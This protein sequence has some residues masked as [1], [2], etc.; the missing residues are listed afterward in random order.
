M[1]L[2]HGVLTK[3]A[4]SKWEPSW[5]TWNHRRSRSQVKERWRPGRCVWGHDGRQLHSCFINFPASSLIE[6]LIVHT[7]DP[8]VSGASSPSTGSGCLEN[9]AQKGLQ[10]KSHLNTKNFCLCSLET[11]PLVQEWDGEWHM[12]CAFAT[13]SVDIN[14]FS[15]EL[16]Q[17]QVYMFYINR[18]S[19]VLKKSMPKYCW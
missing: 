18:T 2:R 10:G 9:Y 19:K 3:G 15:L 7:P 14:I 8:G 17:I 13:P 5:K 6:V 11:I 4:R 16:E 12:W 1:Y